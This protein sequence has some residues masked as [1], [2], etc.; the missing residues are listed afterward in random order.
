LATYFFRQLGIRISGEDFN[1][2]GCAHVVIFDCQ[3]PVANFRCNTTVASPA[4][5]AIGN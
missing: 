2:A 3:L 5:S 1:A 4:K